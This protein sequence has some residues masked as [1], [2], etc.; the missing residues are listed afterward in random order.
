VP[1]IDGA[2]RWP[3]RRRLRVV[4]GPRLPV[5][6]QSHDAS[7]VTLYLIESFTFRLVTP[8]AAV[9]LVYES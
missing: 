4:R 9:P 6:Y 8:E 5:G 3:R 7:T 2:R 1:G